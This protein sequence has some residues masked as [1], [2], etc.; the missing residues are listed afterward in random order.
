MSNSLETEKENLQTD[1]ESPQIESVLSPE[2]LERE[3]LYAGTVSHH[4]GDHDANPDVLSIRP[5]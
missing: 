3:V 5:F 4:G 1:Y 2:R